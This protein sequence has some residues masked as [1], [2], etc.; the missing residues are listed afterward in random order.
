MAVRVVT[1]P[2]SAALARGRMVFEALSLLTPFDLPGERKLR[3][4]EPGDGSYVLIDRL[5]PSQPIMSFGIGPS[6]SFETGI[7]ERGHEVLLF[8]HTIDALPGDHPRFTWFREGVAPVSEPKRSLLSLAAHMDKLP[9]GRASPILKLDIEGA[10]WSV[11][12]A[13][14]VDLL[15]RFEQIALELHHLH[16]LDNPAFNATAQLVLGKLAAHFTLCHVH[17]NNFCSVAVVGGFPVPETLELTYIRSDLVERAPSTTVYPT[18]IDAPNYPQWPDHLLW[19]FPF[20]PSTG[21][22]RFPG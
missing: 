13:T 10:E 21:A 9:G 18:P 14:P 4:G 2:V 3:I 11:L 8:D 19:Y 15:V 1:E 16:E 20:L 6:T 17:A 22:M 5:D 7:A 12:G